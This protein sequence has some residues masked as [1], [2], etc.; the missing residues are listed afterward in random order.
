M[1]LYRDNFMIITENT[2]EGYTLYVDALQGFF[3]MSVPVGRYVVKKLKEN[4][5]HGYKVLDCAHK[6]SRKRGRIL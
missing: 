5:S 2:N 1:D 6:V 3:P 4:E